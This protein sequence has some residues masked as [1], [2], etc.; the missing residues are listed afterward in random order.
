MAYAT[1]V[2]TIALK[3]AQKVRTS[4][5]P[6]QQMQKELKEFAQDGVSIDK[7]SD[8]QVRRIS[9]VFVISYDNP[10]IG[11]DTMIHAVYKTCKKEIKKQ[12]G[13]YVE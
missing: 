1:R 8:E 2:S 13:V 9:E 5:N 6:T 10:N 12:D 7:F 4:E 11:Q 3:I